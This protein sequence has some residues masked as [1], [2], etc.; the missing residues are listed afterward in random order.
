M[1]SRLLAVALAAVAGACSNLTEPLEIPEIAPAKL[2]EIKKP[3]ASQAS[4]ALAKVIVNIKRGTTVFHFP[5][6]GMQ[7]NESIYCNLRY[8][9]IDAYEDWAS[10]MSRLG[11]WNTE[12]GEVFYET[13]SARGLNVAGDPKDLFRREKAAT[14]AE[15]SVGGRIT[16][17]RGNFCQMHEV[18]SGHP[19]P[20]FSGEMFLDIDWTIFS[21]VIKRKVLSVRTQGYFKLKKRRKGGLA[22]IFN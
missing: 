3:L 11:D 22:V 14:S 8:T 5:A 6:G 21:N 17:M 20:E 1:R 15:Y 13:L 7:G 10:G 2:I 19:L 4:F 16:E 12:L 9:D 18:W